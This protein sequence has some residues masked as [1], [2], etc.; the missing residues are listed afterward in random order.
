MA[1]LAN[2]YS[3][4]FEAP[5]KPSDPDG[6]ILESWAQGYMVGSLVIMMAITLANMRRGVILHKLILLEL[7]LGSFMGTFI[8]P[9]PPVYGWYLSATAIPL[10]TS[11]CLHNVISWLKIKPFLDKKWSRIFIATVCL[12][13]PYWGV[14]IYANFAFFNGYNDM[15][16]TTRPYEAIFRDPWW[17][18]TTIFLFYKI[19]THYRIALPTLVWISPRFG[20]LLGAMLLSVIFIILDVLSVTHVLDSALPDGLNP[21]WKLS[22]VFKCLTD[23]IILDDFKTALDRLMRHKLRRDGLQRTTL[24]HGT[25]FSSADSPTTPQAHSDAYAQWAYFTARERAQEDPLGE[26]SMERRMTNCTDISEI[27]LKTHLRHH[28]RASNISPSTGK[29]PED[30]RTRLPSPVPTRHQ[31]HPP[32]SGPVAH[33]EDLH[34]PEMLTDRPKT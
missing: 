29:E 21:F 3:K 11:W 6:L 26:E 25:T 8:F 31:I 20:V 16:T 7:V 27:M 23:S 28:S 15:F 13:F 19:A 14:E 33:Y 2:V 34:L 9:H 24:E 18:V 32:L 5:A 12:S 22:T 30:E 4:R 1:P 17:I 10:N